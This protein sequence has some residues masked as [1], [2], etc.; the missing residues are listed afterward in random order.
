MT[1]LYSYSYFIWDVITLYLPSRM[2]PYIWHE[3]NGHVSVIQ[4]ESM[5]LL[6]Q[7]RSCICHIK[8][9]FVFLYSEIGHVSVISK[10]PCIFLSQNRLCTHQSKRVQIAVNSNLSNKYLFMSKRKSP[11]RHVT[12]HFPPEDGSV[13]WHCM[14]IGICDNN[15][16]K[17]GFVLQ[18]TPN[19]VLMH[20]NIRYIQLYSHWKQIV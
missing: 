1:L 6:P 16:Q 20:W 7:N 15:R 12:Y 5:Y 17:E 18:V 9:V 13:L 3:K 8:S 11:T 19:I 10:C 14:V 2:G 4:N